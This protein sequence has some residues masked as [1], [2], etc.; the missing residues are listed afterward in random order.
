MKSFLK[1]IDEETILVAHNAAF[2]FR[3]LNQELKRLNLPLLTEDQIFDTQVISFLAIIDQSFTFR[4]IYDCD[5]LHD[6]TKFNKFFWRKM[7]SCHEI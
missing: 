6:R 1:F 5:F 2:D 4:H 3:M 7:K